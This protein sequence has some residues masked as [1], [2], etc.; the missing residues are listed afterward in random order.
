MSHILFSYILRIF[1]PFYWKSRVSSVGTG[2]A[3]LLDGPALIPAMARD[4][5]VLYM[6]QTG[7][8]AYP[9]SY[10]MVTGGKSSVCEADYSLSPSAEAKNGGGMLPLPHMS[11]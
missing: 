8:G 1:V 6:V 7:S 4:F 5:S 11:L 2:T 9:A 10:P 3:Y